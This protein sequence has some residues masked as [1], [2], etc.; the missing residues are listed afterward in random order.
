MISSTDLG[1]LALITWLDAKEIEYGWHTQDKIKKTGC[2]PILSVGWIADL[3]EKEV[4]IS[5]DIP[6]DKDDDE[7]GRSQSI[8]LGCVQD[9]TFWDGT[10]VWNI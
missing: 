3:T 4:K 8:P 5:A 1:K 9:V 7:A 2:P 10:Y 6:L